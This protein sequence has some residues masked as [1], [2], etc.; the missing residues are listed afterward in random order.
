MRVATSVTCTT[1]T[2][3]LLFPPFYCNQN[4]DLNWVVNQMTWLPMTA[5]RLIAERP[6]AERRRG[7][8]ERRRHHALSSS[9][10][11]KDERGE[12]E[13]E[14]KRGRVCVGEFWRRSCA[15]LATCINLWWMSEWYTHVY[16]SRYRY[17]L[18]IFPILH[19]CASVCVCVYFRLLAAA[20]M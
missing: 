16:L 10:A 15:K 5:R 4:T 20:E 11:L 8:T 19:L 18:V 12:E 9:S 1:P 7:E 14:R 17:V 3:D 2:Y 6:R 13:R